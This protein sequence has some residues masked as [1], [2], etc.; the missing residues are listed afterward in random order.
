MANL[1]VKIQLGIQIKRA[2]KCPFCK[3]HS[4][5]QDEE[6]NKATSELKRYVES[7]GLDFSKTYLDELLNSNFDDF[8]LIG[9]VCVSNDLCIICVC[10]PIQM[11]KNETMVDDKIQ[12]FIN[13]HPCSLEDIRSLTSEYINVCTATNQLESVCFICPSFNINHLKS[14]R[15]DQIVDTIREEFNK[16]K[17]DVLILPY[18]E[19]DEYGHRNGFILM[20]LAKENSI[21]VLSVTSDISSEECLK[22]ALSF[23]N[24]LIK[25]GTVNSNFIK[26]VYVRKVYLN[27]ETN[28][29]ELDEDG[30]F[31]WNGIAAAVMSQLMTLATNYEVI[32]NNSPQVLINC[33]DV[34]KEIGNI[35]IGKRDYLV[36]I[37]TQYNQLVVITSRTVYGNYCNLH[38]C[39]KNILEKEVRCKFDTFIRKNNLK[40]SFS[41]FVNAVEGVATDPSESCVICM[42]VEYRSKLNQ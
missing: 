3:K 28:G 30:N 29:C 31:N 19:I 34:R 14:V 5:I 23:R 16:K 9:S 6:K 21:F 12:S 37:F 10:G 8:D 35:L 11:V 7:E 18:Y 4:S 33:C 2:F 24:L 32:K 25:S 17:N 15:N 41:D 42:A 13:N 1:D 40:I 36:D 26:L 22:R 20:Y 27:R 39:H 38:K